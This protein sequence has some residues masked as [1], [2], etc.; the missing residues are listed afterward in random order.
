M[1]ALAIGTNLDYVVILGYFIAILGFGLYFGRYTSCTKDY[2][3]GGQRFSW[4]LIAFSCVATVVGSYSFIKY[5]AAGFTY[6]ISSTQSYL[7]D[8]FWMPILVLIWIPIIYY[9]KIQSIPEYMEARFSLPGGEHRSLL[10]LSQVPTYLEK[11]VARKT[12][13]LAFCVAGARNS[14]EILT[15]INTRAVDEDRSWGMMVLRYFFE[16]HWAD[17]PIPE[18]IRGFLELSEREVAALAPEILKF[19]RR[20]EQLANPDRMK[21]PVF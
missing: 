2:F 13:Y 5:S 15:H 20:P 17:R 8:W 7:N 18:K 10:S 16:W 3:F 21:R 9:R 4:W 11:N 1:I 12:R 14:S 19:C 6:G